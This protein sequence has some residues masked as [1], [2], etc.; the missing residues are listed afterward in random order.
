MIRHSKWHQKMEEAFKYGF[1]RV[2][3]TDDCSDHFNDCQHNKKQTHYHCIQSEGC[4]KVSVSLNFFL[5]SIIAR[6]GPHSQQ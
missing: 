5:P 4:D 3:P 6:Q 2:T 1:R